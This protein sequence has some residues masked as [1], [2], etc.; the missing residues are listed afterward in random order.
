MIETL[1]DFPDNVV[2]FAFHGHVTKTDYQTVLIPA[3]EDRLKRHK[4]VRIYVEFAPDFAGVDP[5]ALWEDT[6]LD[7]MLF[8]HWERCAVVTDEGWV[9]QVAKFS[10]FFGFLWPGDYRAFSIAEADKA[11]DWIIEGQQ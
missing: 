5:G 11:R 9:K 6:K 2:A 7:F 4:K 1:K 8:F 10:E 3:F